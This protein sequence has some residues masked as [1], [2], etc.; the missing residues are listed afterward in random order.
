MS[1]F[2]IVGDGSTLEESIASFLCGM[3][4]GAT[5]VIVG[6][7]LDT[8]KTKL[9]ADPAYKNLST[10]RATLNIARQ[11]GIQGFYKGFIPPLIGSTFFRSIQF[12]SYGAVVTFCK[13][14]D[15]VLRR[16]KL[17]DVEARVFL[18]GAVAG[19]SR[20]LIESPLDLIKTRKQTDPT[21]GLR[22]LRFGDLVKGFSATAARNILLLGTF[23]VFLDRLQKLDTLARGGVATTVAWTAVWPLDVA[24]SRMQADQ[25]RTSTSLLQCLSRAAKDGSLYRGYT[26]GISRSIVANSASLKA[27]QVGQELRARYFSRNSPALITD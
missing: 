19:L 15:H 13:D 14:E 7:P 18:G 12:A 23:F 27:Y 24:K 4:F 3:L 16:I 9:Q 25:G 26:A 1:T 10:Y 5:T 6:H 11:G 8:I 21:F 22:S 2:K 17:A 20:A